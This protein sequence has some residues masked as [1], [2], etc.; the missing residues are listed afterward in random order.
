[1]RTCGNKEPPAPEGVDVHRIGLVLT[2]Q[3]NIACR[4]CWF[5]SGPGRTSRMSLDDALGYISQAGE[6]STMEWIS[7]SGGEPFLFPE[8]L[9]E[10][11]SSA[12]KAGLHTECVTNCFW[13]ETETAAVKTLQTLKHAGLEVLNI[14]ADDFHQEHLPFEYVGNCYRASLRLGLK[15]VIMCT[16]GRSSRLTI[17]RVAELLGDEGIRI[18][19]REVPYKGQVTALAVQSGFIPLG[20]AVSI[21]EEELMIGDSPTG[22]PCGGG[23]SGYL[24][25][26]PRRRVSLLFRGRAGERR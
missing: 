4:H 18:F 2:E 3:C 11:I 8:M 26:T 17:K 23:A 13:A 24:H 22:G 5:S 12:A 16:V 10:I 15:P 14:S 20:R 7:I 9:K 21:A 6:I 25:F 19:G 1:M